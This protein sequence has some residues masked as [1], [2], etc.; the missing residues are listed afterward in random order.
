MDKKKIIIYIVGGIV[1]LC[2]LFVPEIISNAKENELEKP[3]ITT[4][5]TTIVSDETGIIT[6]KEIEVNSHEQSDLAVANWF[7]EYLTSE[8]QS[9][10]DDSLI[11]NVS[12]YQFYARSLGLDKDYFFNPELWEVYYNDE[13]NLNRDITEEDIY[14]IRLNPYKLLDLYAERVNK[15]VDELCADLS[16][17]KQTLY[18]NWGYDPCSVDYEKEHKANKVTYSQKEEEIFG[19]FNYED[20]AS[21]MRTK[22]LVVSDGNVIFS[23]S[24]NDSLEIIRR[25]NLKTFSDEYYQYSKYSD[26]ERK[27]QYSIDNIGIRAVIPIKIPNAYNDI[28]DEYA[29]DKEVTAMLNYSPFAYGCKSE[30]MIDIMSYFSTEVNED[31]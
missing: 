21:I 17:S 10:K 28:T 4:V 19:K 12:D 20:R 26:E 31:E 25:D 11:K 9:S 30:D 1:S 13:I 29:A 27:Q 16:V 15:T 23:D 24:P 8:E 6:E 14:L 22:M 7:A 5:A 2:V 18:Y 3:K